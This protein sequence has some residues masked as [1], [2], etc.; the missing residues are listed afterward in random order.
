MEDEPSTRA[1]N[2]LVP[3][4]VAH[5][6]VWILAGASLRLSIVNA[7]VDMHISG[8]NRA[9]LAPAHLRE[10]LG[11]PTTEFQ[12]L[13]LLGTIATALLALALRASSPKWLRRV[14]LGASLVAVW[15]YLLSYVLEA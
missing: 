9:E 8:R 15:C 7:K 1:G 5:V 13:A 14:T 3:L 12:V 4:W 11:G 2:S 6:A 10:V